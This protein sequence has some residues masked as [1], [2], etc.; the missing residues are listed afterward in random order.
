MYVCIVNIFVKL[1]KKIKITTI[2]GYVHNYRKF[3]KSKVFLI[4]FEQFIEFFHC[5]CYFFTV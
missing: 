1:K 5:T 2:C 4:L 3:S